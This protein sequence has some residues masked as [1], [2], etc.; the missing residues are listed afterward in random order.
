MEDRV[1]QIN[2]D[3]ID[4]IRER[5]PN[6]LHFAIDDTH[7]EFETL[8]CLL[9]KIR[10]DAKTDHAY[11]VGDY[12][13]GGD[14]EA[15]LKLISRNYQRDHTAPGYHLIRGNHEREL[16]PIFSL[17]NL[18]DVI[19]YKGRILDYY[20]THAGMVKTAFDLIRE[21]MEEDPSRKVFA[22]ALSKSVACED[23]PLRQIVWSR[24]GLYSQSSF[25][26]FWPSEYDLKRARACI[27][28]GHTPFC[29]LKRDN[30]FSYGDKNLFWQNQ[31]IW[32][33]E[34]LQSFDIDSNVK[35]RLNAEDS[36]RGL[37]CVCLEVL[38]EIA[39]RGG[40][41]LKREEIKQS[42]NFV[43]SVPRIYNCNLPRNG[44]I[45]RIL[46]AKPDMKLIGMDENGLPYIV[47]TG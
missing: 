19:V 31:R 39:E 45:R 3:N 36:Y 30:V 4:S 47:K 15:L 28:H 40:G 16:W 10:F 26:R 46:D 9:D 32:F 2:D 18:P 38:D 22:Y 5:Y 13:Y 17:K 14:P 29:M 24:K 44:N 1:I 43:F 27:I 11:F 12:N 7:G 25:N 6:G 34:D 41:S 35:G 8:R 33:A 21:D 42:E 23:A 20:I 37:S